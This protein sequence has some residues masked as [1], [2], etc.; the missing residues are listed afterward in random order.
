MRKCKF[1]EIL[2]N[3]LTFVILNFVTDVL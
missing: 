3:I 1:N 2:Q